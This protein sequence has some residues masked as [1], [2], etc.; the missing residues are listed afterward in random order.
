MR[1]PEAE[2]KIPGT[3]VGFER[4]AGNCKW[5]IENSEKV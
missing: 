1:R 3:V 5:R 4:G 2:C